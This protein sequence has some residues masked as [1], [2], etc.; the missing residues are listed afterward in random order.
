MK[1]SGRPVCNDNFINPNGI[2]LIIASTAPGS[3]D[4]FWVANNSLAGAA[5]LST[6]FPY[7][8]LDWLASNTSLQI[9][10]QIDD[11]VIAEDISVTGGG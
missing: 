2:D 10:H 6:P 9:Y 1:I 3:V 5:D 7:G 11:F 4:P 8:R